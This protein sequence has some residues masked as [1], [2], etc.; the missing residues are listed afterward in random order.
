[1]IETNKNVR[2]S[3][4]MHLRPLDYEGRMFKWI[5]NVNNKINEY[6]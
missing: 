5:K 4:R 3:E 2:R 1:M 6:S